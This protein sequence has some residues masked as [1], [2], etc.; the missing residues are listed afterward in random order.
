MP[1]GTP[2]RALILED[3]NDDVELVLHLLRREGFCVDHQVVQT[4]SAYAAALDSHLDIII[5][6]YSLPQ[7]TALDALEMLRERGLDVP[8]IIVTGAVGEEPAVE[9]VRRGAADYLLKDRLAR[10]GDA[11]RRTLNERRL[12]EEQRRTAAAL[13][14]SETRFRR[15]AENAQDIIFRYRTSDPPGFEYLSP[16]VLHL[17]G[18]SPD[19]FYNDASLIDR[20][21][22]PDDKAVFHRGS[23]ETSLSA[24]RIRRRDG[25]MLWF[26]VRAVEA[27]N[28]EN[29]KVAVE[30]IARDVTE[31]MR[32]EQMQRASQQWLTAIFE[33]SRDGI[34]VEADERVVF[35]NSAFAQMHGYGSAQEL[36]GLPMSAVE[37]PGE[38]HSISH[39][40]GR[41]LAGDPVPYDYQ[42]RGLR[43][44]GTFL[45]LEASIST[46]AISGKTY[47]IAVVHDVSGRNRLEKQFQQAQ[48]MEAVGR[49]A[50]GIAHDFNNLLTAI[51]GYTDLVRHRLA[52]NSESAR[53]LAEVLRA[54]ESAT[55]L[56]RR[57]LAFSRK[58]VLQP[59][60][61]DVN[62]VLRGIQNMVAHMI[63]EDV[64][65]TL[66]LA[67]QLH[68][69]VADPSRIEQIA[70]NLLVN[71]RD[72][73]PTGGR[74]T[75]ATT[76]VIVDEA[77]PAGMVPNGSYVALA[78]SDTGE[79]MA[80]DVKAHLFEPFFTTKEQGK[81]TGLGLATVYGIVKQSGG[82]ILVE[83]EVQ[84][85]ARFTLYFPAV[86]EPA[87]DWHRPA[88]STPAN[89]GGD[90]T[91]LVVED[92]DLVRQFARRVLEHA[93]YRVIEAIDG[94]EALA[95]LQARHE[96]VD[97]VL[98]DVMMPKMSGRALVHQIAAF[99]PD[100][101]VIYMSGYTGETIEKEW[102][103]SRWPLLT[104]P[105]TAAG[106]ASAVRA[107]LEPP[108][109]AFQ[110]TEPDAPRT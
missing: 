39:L 17:T 48:K 40:I 32:A 20:V 62:A 53:D 16:V 14:E 106:L 9:C 109:A 65:L 29:R 58:Q 2:L 22:H 100:A 10:L 18:Y 95:L 25:T 86:A 11:V 50:G 77:H 41:H 99:Q 3:R 104:K 98:T 78:I 37:V 90:E 93:G 94:E 72:A 79:G 49:L 67:P 24:V 61:L 27:F 76:D 71:A 81:G 5:A 107:A 28:V 21:V 60:R 75:V 110:E 19:D 96:E 42:F 26:E 15:F 83:S 68:A 1:A 103:D 87:Q 74:I 89:G 51:L 88:P 66:D 43:K 105:F 85:G 46:A 56:I 33:A 4:A 55:E 73:M 101:R 13:L 84:Q 45:E 97:L 91:I 23:I 59:I 63:R 6:D 47:I 38:A 80:P 54:A 82:W 44:D 34:V 70:M 102:F 36:L 52:T 69:I 92:E 57:L 35:A 30:G 108:V 31:R 64:E 7:F 8:F 12:R